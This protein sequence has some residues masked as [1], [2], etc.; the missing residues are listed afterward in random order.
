LEASLKE[1]GYYDIIPPPQ[2]QSLLES[3][4][5]SAISI[6]Y[7]GTLVKGKLDADFLVLGWLRD[8]SSQGGEGRIAS[9]DAAHTVRQPA[10]T[11]REEA[12]EP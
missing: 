1:Q 6:D 11:V 3:N 9:G 12:L 7:E 2:T 8:N 10:V 4:G 5:L